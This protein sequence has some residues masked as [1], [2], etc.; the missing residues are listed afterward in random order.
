MVNEDGGGPGG[1]YG[2]PKK[3]DD[4]PKAVADAVAHFFSDQTKESRGKFVQAL[5][6]E[7]Y[8]TV[9]RLDV[10][11]QELLDMELRRGHA[12][13]FCTWAKFAVEEGARLDGARESVGTGSVRDL[14]AEYLA[15]AASKLEFPTCASTLQESHLEWGPWGDEKDRSSFRVDLRA[16]VRRA[17]PAEATFL[18]SLTAVIDEPTIDRLGEELLEVDDTDD[19]LFLLCMVDK[20]NP[21]Q[22]DWLEDLL[23]AKYMALRTPRKAKRREP[24]LRCW[25]RCQ[26]SAT[27]HRWLSRLLK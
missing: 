1:Y 22:K 26:G 10:T 13:Q 14:R 2:V 17:M 20:F 11:L 19:Q 23:D 15:I 8:D 27:H 4:G 16:A 6:D 5:L 18:T 21:A 7:G 9:R 25:R 12:K 3:R 24:P